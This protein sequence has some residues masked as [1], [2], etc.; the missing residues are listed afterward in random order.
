MRILFVTPYPLSRI[1]V[2]SYGFVQQLRRLHEVHVLALCCG[3]RERADVQALANEGIAV[4]G[5]YETLLPKTWR[6]LR[7]LGSD[8]PLQV[9]F[10]ASPRLRETLKASIASGKFDL[11]HIE[12][13]RAL[14]MLPAHPALLSIPCVWDAVDCVSHLY[15]QGAYFGATPLM[16]LFG[17]NEARRVQVYEGKQLYRFR[18]ILVAAQRDRAAL[19]QMANRERAKE[20][21]EGQCADITVIPHGIDQAYFQPYKGPRHPET[22]IFSGKMSF[23]ANVAGVMRLVTRILPLVWQQR[24]RVRL[25][26]AGSNPPLAVRRLAHDPRIMVTGYVADLRPYIAHA[27]LA[28][29][30]LPYA[31]GIQNKILE[32]MALG[33]PVIASS[34][35]AAG[36]QTH[37]DQNLFVADTSEQFATAILSLLYEHTQWYQLSERGRRYIEQ[38]HC[39]D[40]ILKQLQNVYAKAM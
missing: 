38:Y 21:Q 15:E 11:A 10:D 19:L 18:Q 24:P 3:Q 1:R 29:C 30:P 34:A 32:A 26:I 25:V 8:Q 4:T 39:W 23:H 27:R 9:A 6:C 40:S 33:T 20:H 16:R 17:R 5:I 12:F 7:A 22:L 37:A 31:V 36:L 2:R 35:A 14:G 13:V 28:V